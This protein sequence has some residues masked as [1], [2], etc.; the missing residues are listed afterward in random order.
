MIMIN[1]SMSRNYRIEDQTLTAVKAISTTKPY[2]N[3]L[4]FMMV[5]TLDPNG[6]PTR[7]PITVRTI[8]QIGRIPPESLPITP[9]MAEMNTIA[10]EEA[11]VVRVGRRRTVNIIG[12]RIK[13]PP[14]PTMPD[15]IPTK[16]AD[17]IAT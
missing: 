11:M 4:T 5:L 3:I 7:L 14:A 1:L 10:S 17:I 16:N 6:A 13:A 2:L 9:P 12:I 8:G 15:T